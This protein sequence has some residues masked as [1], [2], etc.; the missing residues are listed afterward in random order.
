MTAKKPSYTELRTELDSVIAELQQ[1]DVDIDRAI[2]LYKQANRLVVDLE[3]HLS[4]ARTTIT[5][6]TKQQA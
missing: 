5:N 4:R 6:L 3:K 1:P 2:I